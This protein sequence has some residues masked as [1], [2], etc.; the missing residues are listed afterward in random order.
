MSTGGDMSADSLLQNPNVKVAYFGFLIVLVFLIVYFCSRKSSERMTD[1][2]GTIGGGVTNRVFTSGASMRFGQEL[3][4]TNQQPYAVPRIS[5]VKAVMSALNEQAG[6]SKT[7]EQEMLVNQGGYPDF[8]TISGE[9]DDYRQQ[10]AADYRAGAQTEHMTSD[11][12]DSRLAG[13]F[14]PGANTF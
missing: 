2:M 9:L 3:S 14:Y 8:W 6:A 1:A 10:D 11:I 7:P 12:F 4:A 5:D 13:G